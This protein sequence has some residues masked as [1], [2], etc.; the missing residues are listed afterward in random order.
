MCIVSVLL[1]LFMFL[2][3]WGAAKR[4]CCMIDGNKDP[5]VYYMFNVKLTL[6]TS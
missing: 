1:A 5:V 6:L 2:L 3:Y 4:V